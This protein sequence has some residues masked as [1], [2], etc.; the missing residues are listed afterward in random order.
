MI[1]Q[2][3]AGRKDHSGWVRRSKT[4]NDSP[5]DEMWKPLSLRIGQRYISS[6]PTEFPGIRILSIEWAPPAMRLPIKMN[7][8]Q[9]PTRFVEVK[10]ESG[11][12]EGMQHISSPGL[13]LRVRSCFATLGC[14]G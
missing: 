2:I 13:F 6:S 4:N 1:S 5:L 3:V 8:S 9:S 14:D 7:A 12:R 10:R 11:F